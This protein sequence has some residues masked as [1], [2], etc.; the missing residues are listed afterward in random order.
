M[1]ISHLTID[2]YDRVYRLWTNTDGMGLRSLDDS[3]E[4]IAKF[5]G[6]NPTTNF[7][8]EIGDELVGVILSGHDGRRGFIY[9]TAVKASHRKNG[10]GKALVDAALKALKKEGI[11]KTA[12]VVF[13]SNDLG[14]VFW[15]SI[16][17][18]KREDLVYRNKSMNEENL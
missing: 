6:R 10:I 13:A 5:L 2:D 18:E 7:V 8:A 12:L 1:K 9:H 14:N 16:G 17:F 11:N 15:E 3:L 4:G